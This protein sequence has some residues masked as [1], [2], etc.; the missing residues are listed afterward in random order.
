MDEQ[1]VLRV[2]LDW[3]VDT[4]DPPRSFGGWNTGRVVQQTHESLVEDDFETEPAFAGQPTRIVPRLAE[5]CEVSSDA[6]RFVFRLRPGV[7]FHDG[8]P[9]DA[10]AVALNYA[11]FCDPSS[12]VF[13]PE[14]AGLNRTAAN[15]IAKI[16]AIDPLT[17]EILLNESAPDF[18]R[19]M[20]QEDAPGAQSLV[21]PLALKQFGAEGCADETAPGTG[22]FCFHRRFDTPD[23]P[24]VELIRN[25]A[26]WGSRPR[27][28]GIRFVPYRNLDD[29]VRALAEGEVD[30]AYSLE[31]A[32]L[33][34]LQSAGITIP[35]FSPPYI[36]YLVFNLRHPQMADIR[37]RHA[38]GH[39][40]DREALSQLFPDAST[41]AI[42]TLPPGSPSHDP[43]AEERYPH[44]PE[45]ARALLEDAGVGDGL[46]MRVIGARAGSAQLNPGAIFAQLE[47]DLAAVGIGL[48]I[49][50]HEDWV[51]YCNEWGRGMAADIGFSEMSWAMSSDLWLGQ[52]LHSRNAAP[53]GFNAGYLRD[54]HLD[55][56]LDKAA[57]TISDADRVR[58]YRYTDQYVMEQLPI[59]PLL[60]TRRGVVG[61]S[62]RVK[63]L[64]SVS[65]CWHDFRNVHLV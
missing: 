16:E 19:Y 38:I 49:S 40:I 11:R 28:A 22:A 62:R 10:E 46:T 2:G 23:G 59:L 55:A 47:R 3:E 29:R 5:S 18:L 56:L 48:K 24:G 50:L 51:D 64:V 52:I 14:A 8:A 30:M 12:W 34:H 1:Q 54:Y 41:P 25:D 61:F 27:L 31:G 4:I 13:S 39:A 37:V 60:G 6:R 53:E 17:V 26:Y 42:S 21:S 15:M 20:T 44:D 65:Q 9:L 45:R 36:W 43:E 57:S 7:R 32:D 58:L 33:S 35:E 63:G